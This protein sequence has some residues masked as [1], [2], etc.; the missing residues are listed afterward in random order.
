MGWGYINVPGALA[1]QQRAIASSYQGTGRPRPSVAQAA[2]WAGLCVPSEEPRGRA[3]GAGP[4]LRPL[5]VSL[6]HRGSPVPACSRCSQAPRGSFQLNPGLSPGLGCGEPP[7]L[8]LPCPPLP[9]DCLLPVIISTAASC[10]PNQQ[11]LLVRA[12]PGCSG[13]SRSCHC[14]SFPPGSHWRAVGPVLPD[15]LQT[16]AAW[17][18]LVAGG[19]WVLSLPGGK[20]EE[21]DT[22]A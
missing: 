1:R 13:T 7:T 21:G 5:G 6:C 9:Q 10:Q 11:P 16:F 8:A 15:P 18:Q 3:G 17:R 4:L 14:G 22:E 19:C 20:G 12:P 2:G